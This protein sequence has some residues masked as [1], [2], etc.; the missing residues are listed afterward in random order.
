MTV[1]VFR[2]F[3][4]VTYHILVNFFLM[5]RSISLVLLVVQTYILLR[6]ISIC[7]FERINIQNISYNNGSEINKK[8]VIISFVKNDR[9]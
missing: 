7:L 8:G 4:L 5:E 2:G 9:R 3:M 1:K 6:T